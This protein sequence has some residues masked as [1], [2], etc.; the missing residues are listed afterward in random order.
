MTSASIPSSGSAGLYA[1]VSTQD[2]QTLPMQN[3]AV[4]EYAVRRGWPVA[5]QVREVS[6]PGLHNRESQGTRWA[7][8]ECCARSDHGNSDSSMRVSV[9]LVLGLAAAVAALVLLLWLADF[10]EDKAAVPFDASVRGWVHAHSNPTLTSFM[11]LMSLFGS[12]PFSVAFSI[13]FL[14]L[15]RVAH[16]PREALLF[17]VAM[18]GGLVLNG[19]LKV[20]FHRARPPSYFGTPEP[21]SYSFPS[22]HALFSVCLWGSLALFAGQRVRGTA[23]RAAI[24][25]GAV[26]LAG[27]IGY[28]RIYLGV[29]YPSDV[30]AGYAAATVWVATVSYT[31]RLIERRSERRPPASRKPA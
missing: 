14:I 10:V 16:W 7:Y 9:R 3:H 20:V 6:E 24:F 4:R 30:I 28:S 5:L 18:T 26:L 2:Q 22:G 1:G 25:A 8:T 12:P 15:L 11:R 13:A 31:N 21:A 23:A 19:V 17:L 29:H 27:L